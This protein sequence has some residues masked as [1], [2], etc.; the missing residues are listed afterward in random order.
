MPMTTL[1]GEW[2]ARD[3]RTQRSI[4]G[5]TS[6]MPLKSGKSPKAVSANIRKEVSAGK[7]RKQAVAIALNVARKAK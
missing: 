5:T 2:V 4:S 6:E 3:C 7:P 1:E